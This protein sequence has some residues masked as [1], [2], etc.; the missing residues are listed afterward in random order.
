MSSNQGSAE[1]EIQDDAD[2]PGWPYS[3]QCSIGNYDRAILVTV[4]CSSCSLNLIISF[5]TSV[6]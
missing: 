5:N 2:I 3:K 4:V 6:S 1:E